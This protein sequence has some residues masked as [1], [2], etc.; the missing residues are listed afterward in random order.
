MTLPLL[1][2]MR[3]PV[4]I[5][6]LNRPEKH[7]AIN[8]QMRDMMLEA[9][10]RFEDEPDSRVAILCANGSQSFCSG[11]DI[12]EPATI[13]H[14]EFLPMLGD[15]VCTHKPV[16]AA[17][18]GD[19]LGA[20]WFLAQM[21]DLVIAS[22]SA[23]FGLPEAKIGRLPMWGVRLNRMLHQKHILEI[24]LTGQPVSSGDAHRMGLVNKVT[25]AGDALATALQWAAMIASNAP[26]ALEGC[27][28]MIH[29]SGDLA[30]DAA[31]ELAFEIGEHIAQSDD[32]REG[33]EAF[34][35]KRA[36]VWRGK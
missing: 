36:P 28:R 10:Q 29:E 7:N 8:M 11:R 21:C 34:R 19:A 30:R 3:G 24:M 31:L 17:V 35:Q 18:E 33:V 23:R 27:K 16:I 2:E 26:L 15:T 13:G 20:G 25:T 9:W 4:A 12:S 22:E 14:R 32:A 1:Y 6:T 5:I